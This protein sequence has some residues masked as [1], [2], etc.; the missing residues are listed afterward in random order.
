MCG[1]FWPIRAQASS[2]S[3]GA[4]QSLNESLQAAEL[5]PVQVLAANLENGLDK[6][7]QTLVVALDAL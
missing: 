6:L 5:A 4:L 2:S 7:L 1:S 3:E